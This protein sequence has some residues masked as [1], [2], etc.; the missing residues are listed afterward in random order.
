MRDVRSGYKL[1]YHKLLMESCIRQHGNRRQLFTAK[2]F[3]ASL[4]INVHSGAQLNEEIK[5]WEEENEDEDNNFYYQCKNCNF[6]EFPEGELGNPMQL[7]FTSEVIS[8][9]QLTLFEEEEYKPK[10]NTQKVG[11]W[12]TCNSCGSTYFMCPICFNDI[13]FG[14]DYCSECDT[15]FYLRRNN[16]SYILYVRDIK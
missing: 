7:V 13:E 3:F 15:S 6:Y 10:I 12:G 5:T 11:A 9:S 8:K 16:N 14:E 2:V 4:K 1:L